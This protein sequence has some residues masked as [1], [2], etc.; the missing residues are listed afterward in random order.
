MQHERVDK[1]V[2]VI[3]PSTPMVARNV[4]DS[5]LTPIVVG[6][7]IKHRNACADFASIQPIG[8][9]NPNE[10]VRIDGRN[11]C[12]MATAR[13]IVTPDYQH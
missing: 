13:I 9:I 3:N 6:G 4:P 5:N 1:A 2:C 7:H 10:A 12:D 11:H 8:V